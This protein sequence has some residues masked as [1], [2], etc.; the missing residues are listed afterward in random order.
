MRFTS[1]LFALAS[2]SVA[3]AQG[4]NMTT[5]A[6]TSSQ[7]STTTISSDEP[8]TPTSSGSTPSG[9]AGPPVDVSLNDA[10]LGPGA[11]F[12]TAPD[13][14]VSVVL[15]AGANGEASFSIGTPALPDGVTEGDLIQAIFDTIV[16]LL[17]SRKRAA[18]DCT[19][20]VT[21]NSNPV[22]SENLE[23][24]SAT[25]STT[26]TPATAQQ[27]L[28]FTQACGAV[29]ATLEVFNL[30]IAAGSG[31]GGSTSTPVSSGAISTPGGGNSTTATSASGSASGSQTGTATSASTT[32]TGSDIAG[33][34]GQIDDF[35]LFGCVGSTGGFPTFSLAQTSASMDLDTCASVC[36]DRSFFGVHEDE[37]YCGDAIDDATTGRV[38]IEECDIQCPG[39]AS[40]FCG[41]NRLLQR[42]QSVSNTILLTVYI[43]LGGSTVT[44]TAISTSV[45][46]TTV[47]DASTTATQTVT[48][49][50]ECFNGVCFPDS[51]NGITVWIFIEVAGADCDGQ[52]VWV[53]E[54]CS[55]KGGKQYVEK[56]C[57]NGSCNG[58]TVY[59]PEQCNDWYNK[60]VVYVPCDESGKVV[61]KPWENNMGTPEHPV[62]ANVPTCSGSGCPVPS[63]PAT[64]TGGSSGG[65]GSGSGSGGSS[66][67]VVPVGAAGKQ[68]VSGIAYVAALIAAFL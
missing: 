43:S 19:L 5:S 45:I 6:L 30:Q 49:I 36:A 18:T 8:T 17:N 64:P 47:T 53:L 41:G 42:R 55:C 11:S 63:T 2:A 10:Q 35:V 61:Y 38:P 25:Q 60:D 4:G 29:P 59:K 46:T 7:I 52:N 32:P 44:T 34:P 22:F 50:Y 40:E 62:V 67:S 57:S 37:C 39:D 13:G 14:S 20:T 15:S 1:G 9:S 68:A 28:V 26:G 66:P 31:G 54:D 58:L 16:S 3:M 27:S 23:T 56:F 48:A 21:I 51:G 33:F 24:G 65:S 12:G